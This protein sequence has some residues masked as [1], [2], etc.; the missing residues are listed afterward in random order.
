MFQCVAV[1]PPEPRYTW[2]R[3]GGVALPQ[4]AIVSSDDTLLHLFSVTVE[5]EGV[6][7][8]NV[9]N[10]LGDISGQGSLTLL[11]KLC[12]KVYLCSLTTEVGVLLLCSTVYRVAI[13]LLSEL[14]RNHVC[15]IKLLP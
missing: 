15:H 8:C 13:I 3:L 12:I 9:S 10:G 14:V 4:G 6:Y 2:G 1:G 7:Q 11:C 5:D